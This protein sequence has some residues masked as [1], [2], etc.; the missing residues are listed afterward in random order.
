MGFTRRLCVPDTREL[1]RLVSS[2]TIKPVYSLPQEIGFLTLDEHR[3]LFPMDQTGL[4][5][6][7]SDWKNALL[8][9][10]IW[11][12]FEDWVQKD[13][14][15]DEKLDSII[16]TV[17]VEFYKPDFVMWRGMLTKIMCTP[18]FKGEAW[19]L[20]ARL[21]G[22]SVFIE[23][24]FE[25]RSSQKK[26]KN[27]HQNSTMERLT[28]GGYKF[29]SLC[30]DESGRRVNC[31]A[32]FD[33]IFLSKLGNRHKLLIGAEVDCMADFKEKPHINIDPSCS[34]IILNSPK[35][36]KIEQEHKNHQNTIQNSLKNFNKNLNAP[37]DPAISLESSIDFHSIRGN[38]SVTNALNYPNEKITIP[39]N[40]HQFSSKKLNVGECLNELREKDKNCCFEIKKSPK[41]EYKEGNLDLK[42][43]D[44][45]DLHI[46]RVNLDLFKSKIDVNWAPKSLE[47]EARHYVEIKTAATK[48]R[49]SRN[50]EESKLAK[51]W[52]QSYL[53]GI[54]IILIGWRDSTG[55]FIENVETLRVDSIPKMVRG[56]VAWDPQ[57]MLA[58]ADKLLIWIQESLQ[59]A[60][61]PM[62]LSHGHLKITH[63][64]GV[65]TAELFK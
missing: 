63:V 36:L 26:L 50:F 9:A 47:N 19:C 52:C 30:T 13:E 60:V 55:Q 61:D 65:I 37:S 39:D 32:E 10:D 64:D 48:A 1:R 33:S 21:E 12:G 29:E 59:I 5:T 4:R 2:N 46:P 3:K 54:P 38:P 62:D 31:N 43:K 53:A 8:G 34:K 6:L 49:R 18:F 25:F 27:I 56:R 15:I 44:L 16:K 28:Y 24:D 11:T 42:S 7:R 45:D 23:E 40:L 20:N 57:L 35:R 17:H 58:F 51:W 22:N 14:S 41:D